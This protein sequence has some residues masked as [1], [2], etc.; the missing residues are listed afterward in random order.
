M[1]VIGWSD[2]RGITWLREH[3]KLRRGRRT[4][5]T[6]CSDSVHYNCIFGCFDT[7]F[8]KLVSLYP[9]VIVVNLIK[10]SRFLFQE[11]A[12]S[13]EG[14]TPMSG[15]PKGLYPVTIGGSTGI[16]IVT[17]DPRDIGEY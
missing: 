13:Q 3:A 10:F 7:R 11:I 14:K 17:V 1:N 5:R 2:K 9:Y 16:D 6:L 8:C 12:S 4:E 15:E